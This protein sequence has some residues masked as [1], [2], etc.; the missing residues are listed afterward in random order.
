MSGGKVS[1]LWRPLLRC[2]NTTLEKI[3]SSRLISPGSKTSWD[4]IAVKLNRDERYRPTQF[5]AMLAPLS[6]PD[7]EPDTDIEAEDEPCE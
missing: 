4:P 6:E 5:A 3:W 2:E 7:P 1:T